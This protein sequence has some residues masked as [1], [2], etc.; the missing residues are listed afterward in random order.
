LALQPL[1]GLLVESSDADVTDVISLY[2]RP[3][4]AH[5]DIVAHQRDL[6]R[7]VLPLADD[8]EANLGVDRPAHFL[9]RLAEREALNGFVVQRG[10]DVVGE[11]AGL[12]SWRI[13][14]RR[15]HLDQPI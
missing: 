10:D 13:V 3:Y 7:I 6:E 11:N 15:H 1:G 5:A 9:H 14:D 2:A 8:L 4:R 12:G